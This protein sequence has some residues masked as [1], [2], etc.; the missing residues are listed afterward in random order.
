MAAAAVLAL[1]ACG[2]SGDEEPRAATSSSAG[3]TTSAG[4]TTSL[5]G[6]PERGA[7]TT[8]GAD[9]RP[10]DSSTTSSRSDAD[11]APDR[12]A[13][14]TTAAAT[15]R[16][17]VVAAHW[18]DPSAFTQG[19]L[20]HDGTVF[21]STGIPGRSVLRAYRLDGLPPI[22]ADADAAPPAFT[23]DREVGADPAHFG[24]GLARVGD[25]LIW[26]TW[27]AGVATRHDLRTLAAGPDPFRY[28]GEGWGL[29]HDGERL[30]MSDGSARLTFRN[31]ADFAVLGSVDVVDVDGATPLR[32]LNELECVD[33]VVWANVWQTDRIVL[34]DPGTGAV[35]AEA[36]M[37]GLI[38]PHPAVGDRDAVLNGIAFRPD[39]GTFLVTGKRWPT[40]FEVAFRAG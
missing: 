38:E 30:V 34:I 6:R 35:V 13:G 22:D 8:T 24:E 11:P 27:R 20:Y 12:P 7:T 16:Y 2:Q 31:P 4:G 40:M 14:D 18:H 9:V 39:T 3:S 5:A 36:D 17:E 19:L 29:C 37:S 26:L 33:G 23:A 1:A 25:G 21:E 32:D 28:D 15:L 10:A